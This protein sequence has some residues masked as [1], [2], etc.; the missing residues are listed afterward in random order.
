MGNFKVE[1][2]DSKNCIGFVIA[3]NRRRNYQTKFDKTLE[4]MQCLE[5]HAPIKRKGRYRCINCAD[6]KKERRTNLLCI[7][8]NCS[9]CLD[10][11]LPFHQDH[12]YS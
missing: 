3:P 11:F 2:M 10:C 12:F 7:S 9:L 8:C 1:P 5:N 6:K 4:S